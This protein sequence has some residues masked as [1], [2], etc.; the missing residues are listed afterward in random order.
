MAVGVSGGG[1]ALRGVGGGNSSCV[2]GLPSCWALRAVGWPP[3]CLPACLPSCLPALLPFCLPA[4]HPTL[5]PAG[6]QYVPDR[7]SVPLC[8]AVLLPPAP[9]IDTNGCI[10]S[11]FYCITFAGSLQQ[12][13][14]CNHVVSLHPTC[15][16]PAHPCRS[17]AVTAAGRA[18]RRTSASSTSTSLWRSHMSCASC[19]LACGDRA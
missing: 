18:A 10:N 19:C 13:Y 1:A 14:M 7:L 15:P 17:A 3:A 12:S 2:A 9:F 6:S 5:L 4:C 11:G 16:A 8:R